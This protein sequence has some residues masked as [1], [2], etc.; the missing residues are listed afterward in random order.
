MLGVSFEIIKNRLCDDDDVLISSIIF[1][2][3]KCVYCNYED[4]F[5][6]FIISFT[7]KYINP[8]E[9]ISVYF[10]E[11][12]CNKTESTIKTMIDFIKLDRCLV[13]NM[14]SFNDLVCSIQFYIVTYYMSCKKNH[15]MCVLQQEIGTF[16]FDAINKY[17][18]LTHI[19]YFYISS[20]S[21][22]RPNLYIITDNYKIMSYFFEK[23]P[24]MFIYAGFN[25]NINM[26]KT[27][28]PL[29]PEIYKYLSPTILNNIY[30]AMIIHK[31][32]INHYIS[33]VILYQNGRKTITYI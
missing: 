5:Y 2:K 17:N 18:Y 4:S 30:I 14:K 20:Y 16:L 31:L 15:D 25:E 12:Y 10:Y 24:I 6:K 22:P 7:K 27:I 33:L 29:Y 1:D 21:I 13:N 23:Y 32:I 19:L 8:C 28:L 3:C 26:V 9:D 11:N